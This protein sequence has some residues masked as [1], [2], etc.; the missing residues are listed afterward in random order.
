MKFIVLFICLTNLLHAKESPWSQDLSNMDKD[1][2]VFMGQSKSTID[3]GHLTEDWL[4]FKKWKKD[5][6]FKD[7]NPLWKVKF[8]QKNTREKVAAVIKCVGDC[9]LYSTSKAKRISYNSGLFEG[10]ELTTG[11]DSLVWIILANGSLLRLSP[12]TSIALNEFNLSKDKTFTYIRV[13]EGHVYFE[14]R[15]NGQYKTLNL[16]ESDQ[17]FLPLEELGANREY[18]SMFEY[19][20]LSESKRILYEAE[21]NPGA[22]TQYKTLNEMVKKTDTFMDNAS[23]ITILNTPSFTVETNSGNLNIFYKH[24]SISY[25]RY[26]KTSFNFKTDKELLP[27][28]INFRDNLKFFALNSRTYELPK[29]GKSIT[30]SDK[31]FRF[32]DFNIKRIPSILMARE[33]ILRRK[34]PFLFKKSLDEKKLAQTFGYKFWKDEDINKR[35]FFL[36]ESIHDREKN[37]ISLIK[38]YI[39]KED[40]KLEDIFYKNSSYVKAK[41]EEYKSSLAYKKIREFSDLQY[42]VWVMQNAR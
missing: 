28:I 23:H 37:T 36:R 16:P 25:I 26:K 13:N 30:R 38:K 18:F 10:D 5:R 20:K 27:P 14:S 32:S 21:K 15:L 6:V 31:N 41:S 8:R 34:F 3:W 33:I 24:N 4:D 7:N 40:F 19:R 9:F 12:N 42:F 22:L 29:D 17:L 11:E 35:I 1:G 2:T 39:D